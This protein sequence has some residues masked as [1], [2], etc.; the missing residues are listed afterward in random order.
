MTTIDS[1]NRILVAPGQIDPRLSVIEQK[2]RRKPTVP[3]NDD[4][5]YQKQKKT[6]RKIQRKNLKGNPVF[7]KKKKKICEY[8]MHQDGGRSRWQINLILIVV[9]KKE[10]QRNNDSLDHRFPDRQLKEKLCFQSHGYYRKKF[11]EIASKRINQLSGK[12]STPKTIKRNLH[13]IDDLSFILI[14]Y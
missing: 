5:D 6:S 3:N 14:I 10:K 9:S 8:V 12:S 1:T 4:D 11:C 7:K 13:S 2:T